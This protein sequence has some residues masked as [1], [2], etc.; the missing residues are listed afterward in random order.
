MKVAPQGR[1]GWLLAAG[2]VV[3]LVAVLGVLGVAVF[4]WF[5]TMPGKS[6]EGALPTPDS[7]QKAAAARLRADVDALV[8][9]SPRASSHPENLDGARDYITTQLRGAGYDPTLQKAGTNPSFL[10]IVAERAGTADLPGMIVVG[11]HY[12]AVVETPGAD[13]N[14]SGVALA[15]ELARR[16]RDNGPERTVRFVFFVNEEPPFFRT[17]D[18]GSEHAARASRQAGERIEVMF[19][20]ECVGYYDDTPGS[21]KYPP[22]L[23]LFYPPQGDFVAFVGNI[24]NRAS[25]TRTI[26]LF[27][28]RATL[29]SEG[30]AGPGFIQ[31]LDF[32]DHLAYWNAGY[33][34]LM[35]TDTAFLRN[36]AYHTERD[37]SDRLDYVRVAF[38][39]DGL[40]D[41]VRR[42]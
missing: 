41:V 21:Q 15:L 10:N 8:G 2:R 7:N 14:A 28:E 22:V 3:S 26:E 5:A 36:D 13:D 39:A 29:P 23:D 42:F 9:F 40:S 34:A 18:M 20:L 16:L 38:L 12:D 33:P 31:G 4:A 25:I 37:T 27:R 1:R 17:R 19:S 35:V 30:I 11:A 24:D 6:F 32:S